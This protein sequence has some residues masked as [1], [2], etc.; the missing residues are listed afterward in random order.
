MQELKN[1]PFCA[2]RNLMLYAEKDEEI[3]VDTYVVLCKDCGAK[4]GVDTVGQ[5]K[6]DAIEAWNKRVG[7]K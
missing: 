7:V 4:G 6:I 2:G 5:G 1:C 3:S